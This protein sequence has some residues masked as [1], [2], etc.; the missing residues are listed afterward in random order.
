MFVDRSPLQPIIHLPP[1]ST[2]ESFAEEATLPA[3]AVACAQ[4]NMYMPFA[5]QNEGTPLI[6]RWGTSEYR[7]LSGYGRP[8]ATETGVLK[9]RGAGGNGSHSGV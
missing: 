2:A 1:S 7:P 9:L 8:A 5:F 6:R 4:R 3:E